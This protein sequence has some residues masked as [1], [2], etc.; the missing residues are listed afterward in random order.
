MK[1]LIVNLVPTGMIP[2]K[3]DTQRVPIS[4]EEI[5]D[6]VLGCCELGVT[7][8]H[9][10][11][12]DKDGDP[13]WEPEIYEKIITGIR[14]ERPETIICATCSGRTYS[15]FEKRSAVLELKG[16]AKPDLASLTL[17]SVNFNHQ[18]SINEPSMII[19]LAEKMKEKG[20]RP[21]L[22][23]FD[24]GMIN[25]AKYLIKKGLLK[26]P[27]YFNLIFGNIACAQANILSVGIMINELPQDS[28]YS[29]GAVGD[30]QQ[31]INMLA[32]VIGCGARIG[33]ED[34]IWFDNNR[35][36]L[37]TNRDLLKRLI[38]I[39][40][41]MGRPVMKPI[42]ARELLGLKTPAEGYGSNG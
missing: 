3:K 41:T 13:T 27:Y 28:I 1:K 12:R 33:L 35:T 34:N 24:L 23:A 29:L 14:K 9:I 11:G 25:Y 30:N 42:E 18:A 17:S 2:L 19:A 39:A 15:E 26:S 22:E 7:M 31:M 40:E 36:R 10:H 37:A 32:A 5:I 4:P 16:L 21:E 8:V 20:I 38:S 6:D